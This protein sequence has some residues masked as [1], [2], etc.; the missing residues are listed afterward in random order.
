[1]SYDKINV[2]GSVVK[3]PAFT[4]RVLDSAPLIFQLAEWLIVIVAFQYVDARFGSISAK[5]ICFILALVMSMYVGVRTSNVAWRFFE[6]P[7][8]N[9]PWSIFMY[10]VLPCLSGGLVFFLLHVVV[11][12]MVAAQS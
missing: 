12:Q 7:F 1:V 9:R 4:R 6:D 3:A 5:V 11:K 10:V 2:D 8:K